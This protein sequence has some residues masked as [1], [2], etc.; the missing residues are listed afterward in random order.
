[1]PE[2]HHTCVLA[3]DHD[4]I[5]DGVRSRLES[6]GLAVVVGEARS[7]EQAVAMC[8]ELRP[9]LLVLDLRMQG[10]DGFEVLEA[11][12][13]QRLTTR[14]L[15]FSAHTEPLLVERALASGALAYVCKESERRVLLDAVRAALDNRRYVDPSLIA[16][17]IAPTEPLSEREYQVLQLIG[18]GLQNEAIAGR[19]EV[20]IETIK[21]HVSSLLR[22]LDA[23]T[24]TEAV[25]TAFRRSLLR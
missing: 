19:L 8:N 7:G 2:S 13:D 23:S 12:R 18:D 3:D 1:M 10:S 4:A 17:L 21:T 24:R 9:T 16:D 14:S 15:V 11:L 22:K 6:E 5:R 25:A 20:S